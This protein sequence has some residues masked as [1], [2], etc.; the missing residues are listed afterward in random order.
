[1]T[2]SLSTRSPGRLNPTRQQL[3]ELDA[4]L[5]RMLDLPVN[6]LDEPEQAEV[7]EPLDEPPPIATNLVERPALAVRRELDRP[8][9][10]VHPPEQP[11]TR[12]ARPPISY[13]V[14][15]TASPRPLPPASGFE[16]RQPVPAL[17][18]T[19]V[20]PQPETPVPT[21]VTSK[22]WEVKK[23]EEEE[24]SE[25]L[26]SPQFSLPT[27]HVDPVA[28]EPS[29][30]VTDEAEMWVPLRSTWQPS[31]QTWPPLAESWHLA[32]GGTAP[33][34]APSPI[35]TP[36]ID[37]IPTAPTK[38]EEATNNEQEATNNEQEA[39]SEEQLAPPA[40]REQPRLSLS[41]ED[42]P[43]PVPGLLLPLL[44]FNQGFDACLTPLG[45]PGR[46][47]RESGRSVLGFLGLACLAAA[48]AIALSAGMAWT[49]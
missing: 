22:E 19:P 6:P 11:E 41:A 48:L 23:M 17:R 15:E 21:P 32:N 49:W 12:P 30:P 18:L 8:A 14:V 45:A 31:A 26:I 4:L 20:T 7:E 25:E 1:M 35:S 10:D 27:P 29:A 2:T 43:T 13:M 33:L 44:W 42:A 9:D 34:T 37:P 16:P 24:E 40:S 46:W 28:D 3:D 38:I 47:L 5:Q 39:K 36:R